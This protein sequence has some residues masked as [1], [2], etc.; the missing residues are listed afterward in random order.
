[1]PLTAVNGT[2]SWVRLNSQ[3]GVITSADVGLSFT[4]SDGNVYTTLHSFATTAAVQGHLATFMADV[5]A[6]LEAATGLALTW[7]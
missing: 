4:D 3:A 7:Q 5:I 2:V 6:A 1:M